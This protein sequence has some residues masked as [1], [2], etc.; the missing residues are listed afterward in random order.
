MA[1]P[2]T[3]TYSI[4]NAFP[5]HQEAS[6]RLISEIQSSS[7]S[8][9]LDHIDTSGDNCY[10]IFKDVLSAGDVATL[11][12]IVAAHSGTNLPRG[13]VITNIGPVPTNANGYVTTSSINYT[14]IRGSTYT[15]QSSAAQRSLVSS[16]ASDAA[17]GVG[18]Q[19]VRI[20]YFDQSLNGPYHETITLNGIVPVNTVS[21]N[22]CFIDNMVVLTAGSS[23]ANIGSISLMTTIAGGGTILGVINAGDNCTNW[24]HHYVGVG[25]VARLSYLSVGISG[26]YGGRVDIRSRNPVAANSVENIIINPVVISPGMSIL[27]EYDAPA[28]IIGPSVIV[29]YAKCKNAAPTDW[30]VGFGYFEDSTQ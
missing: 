23:L 1:T 14:A 21:T 7:I 30:L 19:T 15:E 4:Q 27:F 18:A 24:V 13:T 29:A 22:I 28:Q 20:T 8:I 6:D 11:N 10:I 9:A 25:K 12:A 5:N 2:T 16:S 26:L 17:A 3:Y